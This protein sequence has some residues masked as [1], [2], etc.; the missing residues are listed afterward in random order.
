[1]MSMLNITRIVSK[2]NEFTSKASG[3][4]TERNTSV[5]SVIGGV[6]GTQLQIPSAAVKNSRL[7]YQD[8]IYPVAAGYISEINEAYPIDI[9]VALEC[10]YLIW[11]DRYKL[12]H[13]TRIDV[14][15]MIYRLNCVSTLNS[16]TLDLNRVNG[17][18]RVLDENDT[19]LMNSVFFE[20][21][22]EI[23][24]TPED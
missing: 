10:A 7:H 14:A 4:I 22:K 6:I 3:D 8:T 11:L 21:V 15:D 13:T 17:L 2:I 12:V 16:T 5:A 1:M 9:D 18:S 19:K 20:L 24:H 23:Q